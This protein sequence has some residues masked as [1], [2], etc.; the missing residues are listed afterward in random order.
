AQSELERDATDG[1]G[2][3]DELLS[4]AA[5][6]ERRAHHAALAASLDE[7]RAALAE[8]SVELKYSDK[9]AAYME[10]QEDLQLAAEERVE[11]AR[12]PFAGLD[13]HICSAE[14]G[15]AWRRWVNGV[16]GE[17]DDGV[18]GAGGLLGATS[19]AARWRGPPGGSRPAAGGVACSCACSARWRMPGGRRGASRLGGGS[20]ALL[21]T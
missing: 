6:A 12:R 19:G 5:M 8:R 2:G 14:W 4:S 20:A 11:V 17:L 9:L 16:D 3:G 21:A 1:E 18:I 10:E 7:K 13:A 15:G